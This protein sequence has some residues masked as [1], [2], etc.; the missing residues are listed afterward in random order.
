MHLT[1]EFRLR[2]EWDDLAQDDIDHI[3]DD[4]ERVLRLLL[5]NGMINSLFLKTAFPDFWG[6]AVRR[7]ECQGKEQ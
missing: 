2:G 4:F 1:E 7:L 5:I 6:T 3:S